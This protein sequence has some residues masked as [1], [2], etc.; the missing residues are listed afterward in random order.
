V[1]VF[2][3]ALPLGGLVKNLLIF[4]IWGLWIAGIAEFIRGAAL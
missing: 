2:M 3:W 4:I 1:S